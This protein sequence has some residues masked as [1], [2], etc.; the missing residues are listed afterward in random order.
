MWEKH[1]LSLQL[2]YLQGQPLL[3]AINIL[4]LTLVK[5][6]KGLS[7]TSQCRLTMKKSNQNY[8]TASQMKRAFDQKGISN[9]E[10]G[11]ND[12]SIPTVHI[13]IFKP[14]LKQEHQY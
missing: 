2:Y 12:K 8:Y 6:K 1:A 13:E 4:I 10:H 14:N 7:I 3:D 9:T 5:Q 11:I